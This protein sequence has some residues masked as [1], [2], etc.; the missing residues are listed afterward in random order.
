[1]DI[2]AILK[3]NQELKALAA[4]LQEKLKKYT[5]PQANKAFYKKK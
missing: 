3:E 1:M 4:E 2:D 5:N